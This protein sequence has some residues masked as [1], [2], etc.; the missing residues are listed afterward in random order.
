MNKEYPIDYITYEKNGVLPK[1]VPLSIKNTIA[2]GFDILEL[3]PD[4]Y[5]VPN[6]VKAH[7][8]G[9]IHI[10]DITMPKI[11]E[12]RESIKGFFIAE[13]DVW[14]NKDFTFDKFIELKLT[15]PTWL[16]Y[17]KKLSDYI[18]GNFLIYIPIEYLD[19]L[20]EYFKNQ[21]K[22]LYSDRF[23][24]KLYDCGW[25]DIIDISVANEIEHYSN[26]YGGIRKG[27]SI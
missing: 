4:Q 24:T 7:H 2:R 6:K 16:G 26:V 27:L 23:F 3:T 14:I 9:Y 19:E 15:K 18:V 20:I 1:E 13:G 25:L 22:L 12:M 8:A 10:R 17:K 21:K 11:I 5:D